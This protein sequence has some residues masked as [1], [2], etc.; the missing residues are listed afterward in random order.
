LN[1]HQTQSQPAPG[2][3]HWIYRIR[4]E[5]AGLRLADESIDDQFA[6]RPGK[7]LSALLP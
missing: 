1:L 5:E 6:R 3:R 2:S 4:F 7:E